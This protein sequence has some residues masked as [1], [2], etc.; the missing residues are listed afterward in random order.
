MKINPNLFLRKVLTITLAFFLAFGII[1]TNG[2][3]KVNALSNE[4]ATKVS[5]PDTMDS[6]KVHFG[7][8]TTQLENGVITSANAGYVWGDKTVLTAPNTELSENGIALSDTN[9]FLV[10]MSALAANKEIVGYSAIPTDTML[11][12]DLSNSMSDASLNN[13]ITATNDAINRL[14]ELN[15]NNRVGVVVYSGNQSNNRYTYDASVEVLLPLDRYTGVTSNG[16]VRYIQHS[17]GNFSVVSGVR[18]ANGYR[19]SASKSASGATYTQGGL[20]AAWKEF[21]KVEDITVTSGVQ[22]GTKRMPILVLMS[23]GAPTLATK[24]YNNVANPERGD[25]TSNSTTSENSFVTML[26]A[27]WVKEKIAA[28]YERD[29][30]LLYT[31]GLDVEDI[32]NAKSILNP[33]DAT[34]TINSYWDAYLRANSGANVTVGGVTV[35][36]DSVVKTQSYVNR[37]FPASNSQGLINAFSAIVDEIILQSKYYPTLVEKTG[38]NDLDGYITFDDEL[39]KYMEVKGIKGILTGSGN[40]RMLYSGNAMAQAIMVQ[41][42]FGQIQTG[43]MNNL[44]NSAGAEL[45]KAISTRLG[46]TSDQA[47]TLLSNAIRSEQISY[48]SDTN[49]SNYIAWYSDA[50]GKYVGAWDGRSLDTVANNAKYAVK[51]YGFLGNVG[52]VETYD[53]SNMMYILVQVRK[54]IETGR[55]TVVWA[56]PASLIPMVTYNVSF[57]GDSYE[58]ATNIKMNIDE[59]EPIR[60]VYEVGLRSDINELN[61]TEKVEDGYVHITDDGEYEF[62]TNFYSHDAQGNPVADPDPE[63]QDTTWLNY[64]PALENERY[65]FIKDEYVLDA[66]KNKVKNIVSGQAYS[67]EFVT[68]VREDNSNAASIVKYYPTLTSKT[69]AKVEYDEEGYAYIPKGTV[70][71]TITTAELHKTTNSTGTLDYY[72]HP[73]ITLPST[74]H[75][76]HVDAYLGNNGKLVVKPA[77]GIVVAKSLAAGVPTTDEV[78]TF[79]ISLNGTNIQSQYPALFVNAAGVETTREVAVVSNKITV[80]LLA[81]EK[82]YITGLDAGL[83]YTIIEQNEENYTVNTVNGQDVTSVIGTIKAYT[84]DSYLFENTL[85]VK[86]NLSISKEVVYPEGFDGTNDPNVFTMEIYLP[87]HKGQSLSLTNGQTLV[88]NNEGKATITLKNNETIVIVGLTKDDN[89]TVTEV[90]IPKGYT[91]V[92]NPISGTIPEGT[93]VVKVVNRYSYDP[94]GTDENPSNLSLNVVKKVTSTVN[95]KVWN[96][97]FNFELEYYD[98]NTWVD[99]DTSKFVTFTNVETDA[100]ESETGT[101]SYGVFDTESEM[102]P[103]GFVFTQPGSYSYRVIETLRG[104]V[105]DGVSYDGSENPFTIHVTDKDFDGKL[106]IDQ[107]TYYS[108]MVYEADTKTLTAYFENKYDAKGSAA[109]EFD[110]EKKFNNTTG[111]NPSLAGYEFELVNEN[112]EVVATSP[113]T[114]ESGRTTISMIYAVDQYNVDTVIEYT[115]REKQPDDLTNFPG[116]TF[117]APS[118]KVFVEINHDNNGNV[119]AKIKENDNDTGTVSYHATFTNTYS[120]KDAFFMI[121]GTKVLYGRNMDRGEFTFNLY[122]A[123]KDFNITNNTPISSVKN[124]D[125]L[126]GKKAN[127][128]FNSMAKNTAGTYYY[129]VKE[130]VGSLPGVAYDKDIYHVTVQVGLDETDK[131]SLSATISVVGL[132]D[133]LDQDKIAFENVFVPLPM[134]APVVI[135]GGKTLNGVAATEAGKFTFELY[136]VTSFDDSLVGLTPIQ[137]TNDE[138]G[139]FAFD[140]IVYT[141]QQLGVHYYVVVE[142]NDN[143]TGYGYDNKKYNIKVTA[144]VD[145]TEGSETRFHVVAN[146]EGMDGMEFKNTYE[147]LPTTNV[148][149]KGEKT[150]TNDTDAHNYQSTFELYNATSHFEPEGSAIATRKLVVGAFAFDLGEFTTVGPRYYI[151]KEVVGNVEGMTYDSTIYQVLVDVTDVN[152]K[153]QTKTTVYVNNEKVNNIVFTN[154]Y[155]K[156]A[157]PQPDTLVFEG[158]KELTGRDLEDKEFT[159]ELFRAEDDSFTVNEPEALRTAKNDKDGKFAFEEIMFNGEGKHYYVISEVTGTEDRMTYDGRKYHVTVDV[160]L[161]ADKNYKAVVESITVDGKDV[162]EILFVNEYTPLPTDKVEIKGTKAYST[163]SDEYTKESTFYLYKAND[164]FV[165]DGDAVQTKQLVTGEFTFD[166]G[167]FEEIGKHYYVVKEDTLTS[168]QGM[169]YDTTEYQVVVE[170]KNV[171]GKLEPTMTIMVEGEKVDGISFVNTYDLPKPTDPITVVIPSLTKNLN[172]ALATTAGQFAFE[173]YEANENFVVSGNALQTAK[174]D[175]NGKVNFNGLSLK[176][177]TF[178]YVIQE[179]VSNEI[180]GMTYDTSKYELTINVFVNDD[181]QFEAK[182]T[183]TKEGKEVSSMVFNNTYEKPPVDTSSSENANGWLAMMLMSVL[184][185]IGLSSKK[186]SMNK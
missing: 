86:G 13:M 170:V 24:E 173:L 175:A 90:N 147:P 120:L 92:T 127:F 117:D 95:D 145:L 51:S 176:E 164:Q 163:D 178:Y 87:E 143:E 121:E 154:K 78:F 14:Q 66:N 102:N 7:S 30:A 139:R 15:Y 63:K 75:N 131:T 140:P 100:N 56:I 17:N 44:N 25:G 49:Y 11:V 77:Q 124:N 27:S 161:G 159:F 186:R 3:M 84:L 80:D 38:E 33:D 136:E 32:D 43:N 40:S 110:I 81:G 97:T 144:S 4:N 69:L 160:K 19:V 72:R 112:G 169:T 68:F 50:N 168:V 41:G 28:K 113:A 2:F 165:I 91:C 105:Q 104:Q 73:I 26:T 57:D 34:R 53:A 166:L 29:G 60:I 8:D 135:E 62:F 174:N 89:Y 141:D 162:E 146:V 171:N 132:G 172:G 118:K 130:E 101:T 9:N 74:A 76:Y 142:R 156:P 181:N 138:F 20:W 180:K 22:E 45:I 149:I 125:A 47:K 96:E 23:D 46:C 58:N 82:V 185:I 93:E 152:G 158:T 12:L 114:T 103:K 71:Q 106:E 184:G 126:D 37:Y 123:D 128:A 36:R 18:N 183:I 64:E 167:S 79:E 39:G 115:L 107:I 54:D 179:N 21:E 35:K 59:K 70:I 52:S 129:V 134:T 48:V 122:E 157:D 16:R 153:L 109:V 108:P 55:E 99:V 83:T 137:T 151:V 67:R 148:T 116:V 177:G 88:V 150:F 94:V 119:T 6:W 5:D 155:E 10:T 133:N 182:T 31:L 111:V 61:I 42:T 85:K 65:Y 98:G 1:P